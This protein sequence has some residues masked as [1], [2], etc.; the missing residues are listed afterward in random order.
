[1]IEYLKGNI[2]SITPT[3]LIIEVQG[4]GYSANISLNTYTKLQ[5]QKECKLYI[6]E[7]IREDAYILYGFVEPAEREIF[8]KLISVSGIGGNTA[9]TILSTFTPQE[10]FEAISAGDVEQIKRVKGIGLKTAQR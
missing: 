4:I 3:N 8:T 5:H 2:D 10:L 7:L 1:M 9:R 6:Y